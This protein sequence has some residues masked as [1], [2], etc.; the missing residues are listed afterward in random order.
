M[1]KLHL[2]D[3]VIVVGHSMRLAGSAGVIRDRRKDGHLSV[4][5][6]D[7]EFAYFDPGDLELEKV[8]LPQMGIEYL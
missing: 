7:G 1:S 4:S 2:G 8:I 3:R 6:D 5:F